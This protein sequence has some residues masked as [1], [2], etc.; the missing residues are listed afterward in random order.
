[1]EVLP[2]VKPSINGRNR[3][4]P[5]AGIIC[6]HLLD[7]NPRWRIAFTKRN[8]Q[9]FC[10]HKQQNRGRQNTVGTTMLDFVI[11]V[12]DPVGK[13]EQVFNVRFE[14]SHNIHMARLEPDQDLEDLKEWM[15]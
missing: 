11:N 8:D 9:A 15:S 5:G 14:G 1:M 3:C 10:N 4:I 7:K 2:C 6:L 13:G 12:E